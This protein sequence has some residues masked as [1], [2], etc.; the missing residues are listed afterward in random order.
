MTNVE[1][2]TSLARFRNRV[3]HAVD[4]GCTSY[5]ANA[6]GI[7]VDASSHEPVF[8]LCQ[9]LCAI[10][11]LKGVEPIRRRSDQGRSM[12][13]AFCELQEGAFDVPAQ[14]MRS[15]WGRPWSQET[16]QLRVERLFLRLKGC[17]KD[18]PT[19]TRYDCHVR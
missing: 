14:Q 6:N 2:D 11:G 1:A 17:Q 12:C 15:S 4:F 8:S 9:A 3:H 10:G 7:L 18:D 19:G 16:E 13:A 5:D